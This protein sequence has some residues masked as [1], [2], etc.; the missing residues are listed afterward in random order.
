MVR[1]CVDSALEDLEWL[2]DNPGLSTTMEEQIQILKI[3]LRF[4]RIFLLY[5]KNRRDVASKDDSFQSL[6]TSIEASMSSATKNLYGDGLLVMYNRRKTRDWGQNLFEKI[7]HLKQEIRLACDV[8]CE[9]SLSTID[10][11]DDVKAALE[12]LDPLLQNL[13][14]LVNLKPDMTLSVKKQF[15]TLKGNLQFLR[16]LVSFT[17]KQYN[18]NAEWE[19]LLT[20]FG[21]VSR[22]AACLSYICWVDQS[23]GGGTNAM[24]SNL[25]Q[26]LK[27]NTSNGI[28]M[29]L[30]LL[31]V[32][33]PAGLDVAF[34]Q[35]VVES[36]V[37]FLL[38]NLVVVHVE[39]EF[40][41]L[42]EQLVLLLMY[43]MDPLSEET[44]YREKMLILTKAVVNEAQSLLIHSCKI[45]LTTK[46]MQSEVSLL[47][48]KLHEKVKFVVVE[49]FLV[50]LLNHNSDWMVLIKDYTNALH[51]GYRFL[52]DFLMDPPEKYTDDS[53]LMHVCMEEV[54]KEVGSLIDDTVDADEMTESLVMELNLRLVK[55]FDNL[56]LIKQVE[57]LI[58]LLNQKG[59]RFVLE[60]DLE[61]ELNFIKAFLMGL[62]KEEK[63]MLKQIGAVVNDTISILNSMSNKEMKENTAIEVNLLL[64]HLL[65]Q[66]K[67]VKAEV[68][69]AYLQL[70]ASGSS[71]SNF[72]S[73]DGAGF[74]EFFIE[75]LREI[76]SEKVD[77]ISQIKNHVKIILRELEFLRPFL[78]HN[79]QEELQDF[80]GRVMD[81]AYQADNAID[82]YLVKGAASWYCILWLSHI[83]EVIMIIK[84]D[85]PKICENT[86]FSKVINV[87]NTSNRE[88]S[89]EYNIT[90]HGLVVGLKSK[91][92]DIKNRLLGGDR[93]LEIIPI[94][95]TAGLGKTTL[96]RNVYEDPSI[97]NQFRIRAW[98]YVSQVYD[99][100]DLVA[101]ILTQVIK[102]TDEIDNAMTAEDL[103]QLLYRSLR[104]RKY[105]IVLD[106]IWDVEAWRGLRPSFPEDRNSS[107]I[108]FTSRL[109]KLASQAGVKCDLYSL[110]PFSEEE[111]SELL[112]KMLFHKDGWPDEL[113]I[114][115]KEIARRCDGLPLL[116][117]VIAGVLAQT[118]R[119][120]DKW[121]AIEENFK[122]ST[123]PGDPKHFM[124]KLDMS[125]MNLPDHLKAC[126]LYFGAF[127]F[128][129]EIPVWKLIRLWIAE[130]LVRKPKDGSIEDTAESYLKDLIDRSLVKVAKKRSNGRVKACNIHN[131]LRD[132]CLRRVAEENFLQPIRG[133]DMNLSSSP[134]HYEH[135]RRLCIY[136]KREDLVSSIRP[137]SP[138]R[139]RSL[140]FF[141]SG[142]VL[143]LLDHYDISLIFH[144][145]KILR[146]LDLSSINIGNSFPKGLA[147]L[148]HLRYLGIRG[149]IRALPPSI[150]NLQ[151]LETLIVKGLRGEIEVPDTFWKMT[152]L[153]HVQIL[154]RVLLKVDFEYGRDK[155]PILSNLDT[156]TTPSF[157]YSSWYE[158]MSTLRRLPALRKLRCVLLGSWDNGGFPELNL[159]LKLEALKVLNHGYLSYPCHFHLPNSLKKLTLS[160]FRLPW[161][162]ITE[163]GRLSNLEVL[164]LINQAFRGHKWDMKSGE[165]QKLKY[166][167]L[168]SLD[169]VE[170]DAD[171]EQFPCLEQLVL[172]RC[173]HLEEIPLCFKEIPTLQFLQ[174]QWCN[175]STANSAR[176]IEEEQ[177]GNGNEALK[178]LI[179]PQDF[180][181][182]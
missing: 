130:G 39:C 7:N 149:S 152:R 99:L 144:S 31:K 129:R 170:W 128:E 120:E 17:S 84:K 89:L 102:S 18:E 16:D 173:E 8:W 1:T 137:F 145:F 12:F 69:K 136:S 78:G 166:L 73:T 105:F 49:V 165:F 180:Q 23:I 132:L 103:G 65:E 9:S 32:P 71:M 3:E 148:T 19:N 127:A 53:E 21:T 74:V 161:D 70:Q 124:N 97:I 116:V 158:V 41:I 162:A 11:D 174:V 156:L 167:K 139:V 22:N 126:F 59:S 29:Y 164:K 140:L 86:S 119:T 115:G 62:P 163:I 75:H 5:M 30:G 72:P 178:V 87:Q 85:A 90:T 43:L 133:S 169:I 171:I 66:I 80:R 131:L 4:I 93:E 63:L 142:D 182:S 79:E 77:L 40:E 109:H 110:H 181:P 107:R 146:V 45:D 57:L 157:Y 92:E 88:I 118:D 25:L 176:D 98:C 151:N 34:K 33:Y 150:V 111:C 117:V 36:V 123:V 125:Y 121:K 47:L 104:G 155:F 52:I 141:A 113:S 60:M 108:I 24:L 35:K 76:L 175:S 94:V 26:K 64:S 160:K 172:E 6:L 10:D 2:E 106:D 168:K 44:Q 154:G 50:E 46:E 81:S 179:Y 55:L 14:S 67:S 96:A 159:L 48:S 82:L 20:L 100:R 147:L 61:M 122:K 177:Q 91:V 56:K 27:P 15:E 54:V 38:E 101:E 114:I 134:K 28:E 37:D 58:K 51:E 143:G 153:R 112:Q 138:S 68:S 83:I 42:R 13:D 95:G 135:H